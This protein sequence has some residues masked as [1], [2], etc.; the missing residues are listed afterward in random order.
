MTG[1]YDSWISGP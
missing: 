1:N